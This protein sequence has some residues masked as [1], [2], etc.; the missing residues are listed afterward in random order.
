M[1]DPKNAVKTLQ[2]L[3]NEY[4]QTPFREM[5]AR[6]MARLSGAGDV[7]LKEFGFCSE[8]IRFWQEDRSIRIVVDVAG[9]VT[10]KEGEVSSPNRYFIDISPAQLN[11]TLTGKEWA[12]ESTAVPKDSRRAIR[13]VNRSYR[14]GRPKP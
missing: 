6:D 4:P 12:V 3:L 9:N 5:A 1:K 7:T 2:F 10:F 8:N 11:S 14:S 13:C